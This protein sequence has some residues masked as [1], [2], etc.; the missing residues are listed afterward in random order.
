MSRIPASPSRLLF[1]GRE[2]R[3]SPLVHDMS[4]REESLSNADFTRLRSL[5]YTQSG[6]NLSLDKKTMV[7]LRIRQRLRSLNLLSLA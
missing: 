4:G 7:E 1:D 2:Q 6:I 3:N 5:I